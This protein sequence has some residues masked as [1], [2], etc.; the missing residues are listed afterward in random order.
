M[1]FL[2]FKKKKLGMGVGFAWN[3]YRELRFCA[4]RLV[5]VKADLHEAIRISFVKVC[6]TLT[7]T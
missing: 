4:K 1:S 6:D 2:P 7:L 3:R 5:K